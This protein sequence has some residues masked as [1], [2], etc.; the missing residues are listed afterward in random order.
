VLIRVPLSTLL[1]NFALECAIRKVQENKVELKFYGTH[2]LQVDVDDVN[3]LGY[4]IDIIEKS[5]E[6]LIHASKEVALDAHTENSKYV[7]L[8]RH[9]NTGQN[10]DI[11]VANRCFE[12]VIQFIY[13]RTT[14]T[15]QILIQEEIKL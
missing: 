10:H 6:I 14:V 9:H 11:K 7:L 3:L 2:Q 12:N 15:N 8:S 13:I 5:T 1:F 4:N